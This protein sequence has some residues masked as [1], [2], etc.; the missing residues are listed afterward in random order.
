MVK[1]NGLLKSIINQNSGENDLHI[2]RSVFEQSCACVW[3]GDALQT[4]IF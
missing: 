1:V 4:A 2:V 3:D